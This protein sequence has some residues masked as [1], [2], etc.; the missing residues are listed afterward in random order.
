MTSL[1]LGG[2]SHALMEVIKVGTF[3][4]KKYTPN[5]WLE[6]PNG[7]ERYSDAMGRHWLYEMQGES[8]DPDSK[9]LHAAH[10]AW[11]AL[12]RLELMVRESENSPKDQ[13]EKLWPSYRNHVAPPIPE[14]IR[15]D[16]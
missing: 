7:V 3:G 16:P 15:F 8:H 6:V 5:G 2:F 12:A 4:A 9:L 10:L 11:N 14:N 1:V 13:L